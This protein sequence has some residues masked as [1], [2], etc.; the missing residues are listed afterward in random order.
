MQGAFLNIQVVD[1][2]MLIVMTAVLH[3][4]ASQTNVSHDKPL[5]LLALL[6]CRHSL[7]ACE[8]S[9]CQVRNELFEV[10]AMVQQA[11]SGGA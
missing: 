1:V 2:G 7:A 11:S 4:C 6:S 8:F 5:E 3:R 9:R 10:A